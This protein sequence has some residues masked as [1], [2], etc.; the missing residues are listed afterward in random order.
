MRRKTLERNAILFLLTV[1]LFLLC[2][3]HT[4]SEISYRA[5]VISMLLGS[6]ISYLLLSSFLYFHRDETLSLSNISKPGAIILLLLSLLLLEFSLQRIISFVSYNV[7]HSSSYYLL[8][9]SFLLVSGFAVYKGFSAIFRAGFL[10]FCVF[11][12]LAG[13][14]FIALFPKMNFQNVLPL[15]D[16][17][18]PSILLSI[19]LF[20]ILS[21]FPYFYLFHM[22]TELTTSMIRS[23]KRGF[24]LKQLFL[25]FYVLIVFSILGIQITNL[26]P[27]PEV[28]IFKKVSFLNVIDRMESVF[29]ISYFLPLFTYFAFTLY[30][31]IE[32]I[33]K[34]VGTEKKASILIFVSLLLFFMNEFYHA[35]V[36]I[37]F[38][39]SGLLL[40][41][42]VIACKSK[43]R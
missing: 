19:F 32:A 10:Y 17:S 33:Q 23:L 16:A 12:F 29:S 22:Q 8:F 35:E 11:L 15:L 39:C 26:Y 3:I 21:L 6:F 38:I 25:I 27:Y 30:G 37:L 40:V 9:I 4:F 5:T 28:S 7:I 43:G 13:I 42:G 2:G 24:L 31:V 18:Y 34:F 36:Y 14:T 1:A 20:T 41:L